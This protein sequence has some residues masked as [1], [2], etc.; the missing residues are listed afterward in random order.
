MLAIAPYCISGNTIEEIVYTEF[1]GSKW[2]E[3]M[4]KVKKKFQEM[5]QE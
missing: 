2:E 1:D 5:S 3:S 4:E